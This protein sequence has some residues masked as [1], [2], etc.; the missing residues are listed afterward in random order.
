MKRGLEAY[1]SS[2]VA[3]LRIFIAFL[4]LFPLTFKYVNKEVLKKYKPILVTGLIGNFIP[5]FLFT[6]AE[7]VMDSS[8]AGMLNSL[9][10]LFTLL[11]GVLFFK[12]KTRLINIIGV[13]VGFAGAF[14]L[15]QSGMIGNFSEH[16]LAVLYVL[17]ATFFYGISV[18]VIKYYL[19]EVNAISIS[20]CALLF[21]GPMAGVY[22]F[23]FTSFSEHFTQHPKALESLAYVSIL[24]I[25]GTAISIILYN[26]LI[27]NTTALFASSTTYLIPVVAVMWGILDNEAMKPSYPVWVSLILVGVYLVNKQKLPRKSQQKLN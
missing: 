11:L 9:S 26:I 10:P 1:S 6:K 25:V 22:L 12:L 4:T 8:L 7:T 16:I 14:G 17:L 21:V 19:D 2:E 13:F 23:G 3:A 5:A 27:C 20:V 24:A 18:N 15:A